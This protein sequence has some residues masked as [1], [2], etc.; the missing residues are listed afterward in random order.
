LA[1]VLA[2]AAIVGPA[3][4]V[5]FASSAASDGACTIVG[6]DNNDRMVGTDGPD[7]ICGLRGADTL[8]GFGGGDVLRGGRGNDSLFG[9]TGADM[10]F[11]GRGRDLLIGG[12]GRDALDGG[13]QSDECY[14]TTGTVSRCES[15]T[16]P[17][18]FPV[19]IPATANIFGA[20]HAIPP[21][22]GGYGNGVLPTEIAVRQDSALRFSDVAGTVSCCSGNLVNDPDGFTSWATDI[23]AWDGISGIVDSNRVMFLVGVFLDGSEPTDP[24]PPSL[25]FTD[26]H[27]FR[28][29]HPGLG[30]VFFIGDGLT[31]AGIRQTFH[32]P[33]NAS[34]LFLG[35]ADAEGFDSL[36]GAYYDN[37]GSVNATVRVN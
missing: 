27:S 19:V 24:A 4:T 28:D 21:A 30:Q 3:A 32:A 20:G 33:A 35:F 29:L 15:G 26:R 12:G 9:S 14:E 17:S 2:G 37:T 11:G 18:T 5:A 6:T 34:R 16:S 1:V 36:P 31:S 8:V 10:L 23:P 25:N 13:A 7:V 22:P